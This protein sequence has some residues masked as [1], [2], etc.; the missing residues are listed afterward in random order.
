MNAAT[1]AE[2]QARERLSH[3]V[4]LP[5]AADMPNLPRQ[6]HAPLAARRGYFRRLTGLLE[7]AVLLVVIVLLFPLTILLIG[8]PI[9]LFLRA[10]IEIVHL[11]S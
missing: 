5:S 10:L 8:A 3:A 4:A 9:A 1:I 2:R 6:A 7:D 11:F